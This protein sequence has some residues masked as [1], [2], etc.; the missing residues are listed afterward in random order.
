MMVKSI[1][2]GAFCNTLDLH[3]AITGLENQFPVFLRV[4]V[5]HRFYC[6]ISKLNTSEISM[7]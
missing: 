1:A 3:L 7:F 2:D 6:Y 4:A 5:L